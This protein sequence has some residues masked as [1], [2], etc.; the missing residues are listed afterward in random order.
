MR[1][2]FNI[3]NFTDK[4]SVFP[5]F[6]AVCHDNGYAVATDGRILAVSTAD[7]KSEYNGAF[8]T[9][10]GD[11]FDARPY[12]WRGAGVFPGR[13]TGGKALPVGAADLLKAVAAQEKAFIGEGLR[14]AEAKKRVIVVKLCDGVIIA[15]R[16]W[17]VKQFAIAAAHSGAERITWDGRA[18]YSSGNTCAAILMC[19]RM[20]GVAPHIE[21]R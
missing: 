18:V 19:G 2:K 3:Y 20:Q 4:N 13:N 5:Q 16:L 9:R 10:D 6:T 12:N 8:V 11:T 17:R 21:L 1:H 14:P 15:E 7:Y